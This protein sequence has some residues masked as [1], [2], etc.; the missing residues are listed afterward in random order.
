MFQSAEFR[1]ATLALSAGLA[2]WSASSPACAFSQENLR[3]GAE[4]PHLPIR[5]TRSRISA[6]VRICSAP[7]AP[8]CSSALSEARW[9][10]S[11]VSRATTIITPRRSPT[12]DLW[13]MASEFY[14]H[15]PPRPYSSERRRGSRSRATPS[16][17]LGRWGSRWPRR[18]SQGAPWNRSRCAWTARRD[19]CRAGRGCESRRAWFRES[20]G[21]CR[22]LFHRF[23][24]AERDGGIV[25]REH[26]AGHGLMAGPEDDE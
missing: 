13:A 23:R 7:T 15:A 14:C 10:R 24:Q 8:S 6:A 21:T 26:W 25:T 16:E 2:A 5:T 17:L 11:G 18:S 4:F 19:P 12:L 9:L 3:G 1:L 22:R 20:N